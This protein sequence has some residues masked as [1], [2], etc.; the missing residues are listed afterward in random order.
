MVLGLEWVLWPYLVTGLIGIA[1]AFCYLVLGETFFFPKQ[2]ENKF[3]VLFPLKI[4]Q[5]LLPL[6]MPVFEEDHNPEKE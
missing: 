1:C 2:F 5:G 6:K 3:N 4:V